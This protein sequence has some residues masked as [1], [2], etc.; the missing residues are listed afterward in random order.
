M[1]ITAPL[2][3]PPAGPGRALLRLITSVRAS[4]WL[5]GA[6]VALFLAGAVQM[7][8]M[9]E[10][11]GMND[12]PLFQWLHESPPR[13]TWWLWA[14]VGAMGLLVI[15]TL[16]CSLQSIFAR[17]GGRALALVLSPQII[18]LGF[19]FMLLAHLVSSAGAQKLTFALREGQAAQLMPGMIVALQRVD[20]RL[21]P[22]GYP[23]DYQA[24]L[25]YLGPDGQPVAEGVSAPN[26]PSYLPRGHGGG[27][28]IKDVRP[29]A[30][31]FEYHRDPGAP[32]ALGGGALF[33]LGTVA[34]VGLKIRR[35]K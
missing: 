9:P 31:L 4:L 20:I 22:E 33:T 17:R 32:Y 6:Q 28:Y 30:A 8:L 26:R 18:H 19:L 14:S 16:A 21:S 13:A 1:E 15:N 12:M 29:G 35:G 10:Y 34:L 3:E 24:R 2:P 25:A 7:P 5:L 23:S 27:V 11:A